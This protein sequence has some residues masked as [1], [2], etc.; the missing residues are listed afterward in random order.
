MYLGVCKGLVIDFS[1]GGDFPMTQPVSQVGGVNAEQ[2]RGGYQVFI[3]LTNHTHHLPTLVTSPDLHITKMKNRRENSE[4]A[5]ELVVMETKQL[6]GFPGDGEFRQV[7]N[8][9]DHGTLS[10]TGVVE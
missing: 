2:G 9:I 6:H 7:V 1:V 10:L 8:T 5:P 3:V 4:C